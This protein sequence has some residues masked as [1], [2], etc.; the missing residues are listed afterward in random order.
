MT[1]YAVGLMG[2]ASIELDA[3]E[4]EHAPA[5]PNF[6]FHVYTCL[7]SGAWHDPTYGRSGT[8]DVLYLCPSPVSNV[9]FHNAFPSATDSCFESH[10]AYIPGPG[11]Y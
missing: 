5:D 9:W 6:N 10:G 2:T 3:P 8:A 11:C 1:V 4:N 7:N